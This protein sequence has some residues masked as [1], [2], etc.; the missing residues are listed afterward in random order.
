ML[1]SRRLPAIES[2][3][4]ASMDEP[5]TMEGF[6][7]EVAGGWAGDAEL[8]L[9][10]SPTEGRHRMPLREIIGDYRRRVGMPWRGG[11]TL[12]RSTTPAVG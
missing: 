10:P 7:V 3:G 12:H 4:T 9:F 1:P 5:V 6:D 8:L 2:D 11:T